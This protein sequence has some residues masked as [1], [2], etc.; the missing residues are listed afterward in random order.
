MKRRLTICSLLAIT[1]ALSLLLVAGVGANPAYIV[2]DSVNIGDGLSEPGHNLT[3]WTNIWSGCGWCGPDGN[4]RLIWGDGGDTCAPSENWAS[5][6]L[7]AG[8]GVGKSLKMDHLDGAADDGFNVYVDDILVG[9]YVD[10]YN[11][12]TWVLSDDFDIS[13]WAFSGLLTIKLE[14]TA[15]PWGGCP[16]YGQVAFNEIKLWGVIGA[17]IDIDPNT[18]NLKSKGKFVTAYIELPSGYDV[19]LIDINSILLNGSVPVELTPTEVG[20]YDMDSVSDLMV[21]FD[22]AAAQGILEPGEDVKITITG[23]VDGIDFEGSD[24]VRVIDK[25]KEHTSEDASSVVEE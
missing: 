25:G 7:D 19:N 6:T 18:L 8:T 16:T 12:N 9:T 13:S 4:M 3:D 21:K 15:D 14:A 20:D 1:L 23:Q 2:L 5:I 24:F 11:S 10:Q 17:T 22:R